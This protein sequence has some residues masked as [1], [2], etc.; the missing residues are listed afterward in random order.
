MAAAQDDE[1]DRSTAQCQLD[2]GLLPGGDLRPVGL[3]L[4]VGGDRLGLVQQLAD[5]ERK[6]VLQFTAAEKPARGAGVQ[7]VGGQRFAV[8]NDQ[9][10]LGQDLKVGLAAI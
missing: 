7:E 5:V 9:G 1:R 4:A 10:S 3:D 2:D 6:N 8:E